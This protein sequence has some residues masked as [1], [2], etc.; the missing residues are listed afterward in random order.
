MADPY[1]LIRDLFEPP[2]AP[3]LED[4]KGEEGLTEGRTADES[5]QLGAVK[6][7]EGDYKAAVEHFKRAVEQSASGDPQA[8]ADLG[9]AYEVQQMAPQ[10]YRQYLKAL[11]VEASGELHLGLGS[12]YRQYGRIS[13]AIK[14]LHEAVQF[15]PTNAYFHFQLAELLRNAGYRQ[16]ALAAIQSTVAL[17]AD[18]SFYHYWMGDLLIEM[19][20]Y[21]EALEAFRAAVEIAP[22]DDHL[23]A[24]IALAFWGQGKKQEA[25]RA[26]RLACDLDASNRV[27]SALLERMLREAG[28]IEEAD[29]ELD[30]ARQI[31]DYDATVV[32]RMLHLAGIES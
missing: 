12:L 6:M 28:M 24:C 3:N 32:E 29:A 17:A 30:K 11:K 31:D 18:Q 19:K 26:V 27:Y 25:I 4:V 2:E 14:E 13:D 1:K 10:A 5:K 15:E 21:D 23:F 7:K 8:M 16:A 9:A 20:R 22:G